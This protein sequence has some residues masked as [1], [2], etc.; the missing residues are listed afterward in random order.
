MTEDTRDDGAA[1]TPNLRGPLVSV[2]VPARNAAVSLDRTI[3]A[4]LGGTYPGD[5]LE[6][7]VADGGSSD[8]TRLVVDAWSVRDPRVRRV[9]NPART[10]A[11]GLNAAL[12]V[13]RG[14]VI[15]R[16]DAHAE[17][18]ADYVE[19]CVEALAET[20]AAAVGGTLA[21]WGRGEFGEAAALA[22][23]STFGGGPAPF[24]RGGGPRVADTVYLGAWRRE[25]ILDAG[26]FDAEWAHNQDYELNVRLRAAG[27]VVW[28]DPR[29]ASR[30]IARDTPVALAQQ[31]FGYGNGRAA[32]VIRHPRS[33]LSRQVVPAAFAA[34]AFIGLAA[35]PFSTAARRAVGV[36]GLVYG[37]AALAAARPQEG[38]R[39][40]RRAALVSAAMALMHLSWGLGFW[41]GMARGALRRARL[42]L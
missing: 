34:A 35:A 1:G 42:H 11:A 27:G 22:M 23:A 8:A 2:I 16:M 13:S 17:P 6:I 5:R 29:I 28:L 4:L 39:S 21:P 25:T 7:V 24:R 14:E 12:A 38:T 31:Y 3:T 19:R 26:G 37:A 30:T 15:V 36:C 20:G 33:L 32:T 9:D 10:T 41:A 40:L 18:A